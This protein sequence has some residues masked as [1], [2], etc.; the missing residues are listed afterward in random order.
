MTEKIKQN[1]TDTTEKIKQNTTNELNYL[2]KS[3]SN[4][5]FLYLLWSQQ[6]NTKMPL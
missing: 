1:T 5:G 2:L 6:H 4:H 3:V